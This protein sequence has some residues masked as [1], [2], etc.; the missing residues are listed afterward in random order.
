[1]RKSP[2]FLAIAVL[3]LSLGIGANVGMF[4]LV[5]GVLLQPS[6]FPEP[7][8][9]VRVFDDLSGAGAKNVALLVP[10]LEDLR[11][12]SGIFERFSAIFP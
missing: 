3:T 12:R 2:A 8:R 10:E 7:D 4:T 11:T 9:L 1:M 6:P 5:N